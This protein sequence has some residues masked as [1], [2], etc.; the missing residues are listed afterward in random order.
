[1]LQYPAEHDDEF[2]ALWEFKDS[3]FHGIS[4]GTGAKCCGFLNT[5]DNISIQPH[6]GV[7]SKEA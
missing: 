7:L 1:M 4:L 3:I 2:S 6:S 5:T